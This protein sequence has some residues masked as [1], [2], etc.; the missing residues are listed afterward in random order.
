VPRHGDVSGLTRPSGS[1]FAQL[2]P[3]FARFAAQ[4]DGFEPGEFTYII[5]K[6][7]HDQRMRAD[8]QGGAIPSTGGWAIPGAI[9]AKWLDASLESEI[10]RSRCTTWP[11]LTRELDVPALDDL[12]RSNGTIAGVQLRFEAELDTMD[13]QVAKL[14]SVKLHAKR[15]AIFCEASNSLLQDAPT[16][17]ENLSAALIRVLSFGLDNRFLFGDGAKQGPLGA[18]VSNAAIV[19]TRTTPNLI[20]YDD[21]LNM[22]SRLTPGSVANSV[23]V[24]SPTAIPQLATLAVAIGT[25]GSTI[26]V[27]TNAN[28]EFTILTRPVI[29]SEKAKALGTKSDISLADFS[30][31][32]VGLRIDAYL[33]KSREVEFARDVSTYR[34]QIRIDG[35]PTIGA[36]ITPL[37]GSTLSPFVTLAA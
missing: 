34:L 20:L 27:M 28:G 13:P 6:D 31:Y 15:G 3:E 24:A 10:V 11:M 16:F 30:M 7:L 29:F 35:Q 17:E 22:F 32:A 4:T 26:P 2:S 25:G 5:G 1:R 37:N 18:L 36:P 14:R 19:I 8:S 9:Y 12:D 23:W 33:D 21:L